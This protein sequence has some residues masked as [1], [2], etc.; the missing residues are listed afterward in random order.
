[1]VCMVRRLITAPLLLVAALALPQAA[2]AAD[3]PLPPE[4]QATAPRLVVRSGAQISAE[5]ASPLLRTLAPVPKAA[6]RALTLTCTGAAGT[7]CQIGVY[8]IGSSA[9]AAG[10]RLLGQ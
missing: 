6:G 8:P 10:V 3:A 2:L 1:M 5:S 4:Q 7:R 9:Q